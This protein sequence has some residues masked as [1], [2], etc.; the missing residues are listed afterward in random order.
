M[1]SEVEPALMRFYAAITPRVEEVNKPVAGAQHATADIEHF[2]R[3]C[4]ARADQI[5]ELFASGKF[6]VLDRNSI[7]LIAGQ[8]LEFLLEPHAVCS[9]RFYSSGFF[10]HS[11]AMRRPRWCSSGPMIG[12]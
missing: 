4:E 12:I 8:L 10:V 6:E 2:G 7:E 9:L 5:S 3:R 11:R 1:H